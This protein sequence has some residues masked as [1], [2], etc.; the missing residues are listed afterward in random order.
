MIVERT[1]CRLVNDQQRSGPVGLMR[2][3]ETL[4]KLKTLSVYS[5]SQSRQSSCSASHASSSVSSASDGIWTATQRP[6]PSWRRRSPFLR[7]LALTC[8]EIESGIA[9]GSAC[10]C[11]RRRCR[12]RRSRPWR[13]GSRS[14]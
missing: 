10:R 8:S 4:M 11:G 2:D 13:A 7:I 9:R 3:D 1:R 6:S 14:P 5:S 12:R